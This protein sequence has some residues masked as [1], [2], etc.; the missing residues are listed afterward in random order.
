MI[1]ALVNRTTGTVICLKPAGSAWSDFERSFF[2]LCEWSD[3]A[4]DAITD[5]VSDPYAVRD[6]NDA[7]TG[8]SKW[9]DVTTVDLSGADTL[10]WADVEPAVRSA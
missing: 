3:S 1:E 2:K 7:I 5:I 8:Q 4:F 10:A 9:L 6:E